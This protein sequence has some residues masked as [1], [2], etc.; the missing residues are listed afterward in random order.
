MKASIL[1]MRNME[2]VFAFFTHPE[3]LFDTKRKR[4]ISFDPP[5]PVSAGS[6]VNANFRIGPIAGTATYEVTTFDR[7]HR[8][9]FLVTSHAA[10]IGGVN[11]SIKSYRVRSVL[12]MEDAIELRAAPGGARL[13]RTV[14]VKS[15][16]PF[17]WII[18]LPFSPVGNSGT[19]RELRRLK[20]LI[21]SE[22]P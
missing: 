16:N 18:G 12:P 5:G 7:P 3:N 17:A 2:D 21:E 11:T 6:S 9:A 15:K 1:I 13:T 4:W 22:L 10:S 14:D 19:R 20:A 8:L